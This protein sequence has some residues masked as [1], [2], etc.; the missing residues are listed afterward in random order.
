M[1]TANVGVKVISS[2]GQRKAINKI[3]NVKIIM[4][5]HQFLLAGFFLLCHVV[6]NIESHCLNFP[7]CSLLLV[8]KVHG[9]KINQV[10]SKD[11]MSVDMSC[12]TPSSC[13]ST[14]LLRLGCVWRVEWCVNLMSD[15]TVRACIRRSH[16]KE[17]KQVG[18]YWSSV[19]AL[20]QMMYNIM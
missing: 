9:I 15:I 13:R 7:D 20:S 1:P 18:Y 12:V 16:E 3:L 8:A 4:F 5:S 2:W 10:K 6:E 14:Q 19:P 17:I 11:L